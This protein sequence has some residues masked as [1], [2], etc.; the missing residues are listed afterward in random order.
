MMT[1]KKAI[2]EMDVNQLYII[3]ATIDNAIVIIIP[4][5]R[6]AIFSFSSLAT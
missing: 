5:M 6:I 3:P 1:I 2:T 4:I